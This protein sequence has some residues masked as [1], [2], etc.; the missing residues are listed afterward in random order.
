MRV[1]IWT[2]NIVITEYGGYSSHPV[3]EK[4]LDS[5]PHTALKCRRDSMAE[6]DGLRLPENKFALYT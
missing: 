2:E 6:T 3:R 1:L 4:T 5:S